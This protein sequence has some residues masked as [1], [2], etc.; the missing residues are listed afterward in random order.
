LLV[1]SGFLPTTVNTPEKAI[2]IAIAGRE[3]GIPMMESF[4]SINIVQGK[5]T[6]SPQLMLALANRTGLLE[7]IEI[8]STDEK[9]M[10]T[11]TR[12][13][14]TA[15]TTEFGAKEAAALQLSDKDNYKKQRKV[16]YQWRALAAN[17]RVTFP[18]VTLGLYTPEEMGGEIEVDDA[19]IPTTS[20]NQVEPKPESIKEGP[21][22]TMTANIE[23]NEIW[24]MLGQLNANNS[25][26]MDAHLK[27]LSTYTSTKTGKEVF[28]TFDDLPSIGE[29][30]PGWLH[31][32][33]KK[34]K[35]A[36]DAEFPKVKV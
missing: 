35:A 22:M 26:A 31:G 6:V 1:K 34:V 20:A 33:W 3:L 4:R 13:G 25:E 24:A 9:C 19:S 17:L 16:M 18:D 10:V 15:Y 2:A 29:K 32:L 23:I 36:Y 30:L 7:N 12:K 28:L 21:K 11:I 27:K 5:P 8:N 14:R